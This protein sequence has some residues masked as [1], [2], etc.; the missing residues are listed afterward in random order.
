MGEKDSEG[1]IERKHGKKW[2]S[3]TGTA[4][5]LYERRLNGISE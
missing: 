3:T 2:K 5:Y 1:N 4:S